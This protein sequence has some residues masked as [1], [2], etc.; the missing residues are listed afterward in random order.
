MTTIISIVLKEKLLQHIDQ[1]RGD[2][3]RSKFISKL[4]ECA[5]NSEKKNKTI[6]DNQQEVSL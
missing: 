1:I 5:L 2:V 3:S 6:P 4:L